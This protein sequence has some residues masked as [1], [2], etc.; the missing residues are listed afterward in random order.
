MSP[1]TIAFIGT[2]VMGRSMASHLLAAGHPLVVHTRS[3]AKAEE[4]LTRGARWAAT[5]AEAADDADVVI[6]MVG[7]PSDVEAVHLGREGSLAALRPPRLLIDMTTSRPS[8]AVAVARAAEQAGIGS[9]DAPVS[10]GDIGARNATLSIMVGGADGDVALAMPILQKLGKTIVH[11]GGPG[12]GQHAKMVNQILIA[13]TMMG[14]CEGLLYARRAGLDAAKAIESVASGAAGSWSISNLGPR[15]VRGDFEPG[16][17]IEHFLKDLGIALEEAA[18][19][20]IA[21]PAL[22]LAKQL[23]EAAKAQGLGRKGTQ[24]LALALARLNGA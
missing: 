13:A 21:L 1:S 7:L 16:F 17:Y 9:V 12:S 20:N 23:Y 10:G 18:Q 22:A 15:I 5:P 2:G 24:A 14:V 11:H 3:R 4:L 19:M 8:L 6:S